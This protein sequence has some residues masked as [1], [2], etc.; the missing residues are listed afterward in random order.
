L[1][2]Y[3]GAEAS[4][5]RAWRHGGSELPERA[6]QLRSAALEAGI[7][8]LDPAARALLRDSSLGTSL[9]RAEAAALLAPELPAAQSALAGLA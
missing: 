3:H 9:E 7:W 1:P 4:L 2:L 5:E 6:R 8:S